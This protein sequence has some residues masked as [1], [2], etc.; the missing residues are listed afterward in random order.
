MVSVTRFAT[1]LPRQA[2]T[3]SPY[4]IKAANAGIAAS[5]S[6]VSAAN[7]TGTI[8]TVAASSDGGPQWGRREFRWR[9][10]FLREW[11]SVGFSE[12]VQHLWS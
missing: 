6:S 7:I 9:V 1:L 11:F 10:S 3:S 4:A 2:I 12:S 8:G 5:A